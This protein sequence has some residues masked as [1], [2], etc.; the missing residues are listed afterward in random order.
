MT[1]SVAVQRRKAVEKRILTSVITA[2]LNAGYMISIDNGDNQGGEDYELQN[3]TSVNQVLKSCMLTDDE[4]LY[5]IKDGKV[6][7]WAYFVYGNDGWDVLNDYTV[8]LDPIIGDGTDTQK[9][10][11]SFDK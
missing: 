5:A 9:L 10:I 2:M 11:D 4:R 8:N 6:F 3:G 1:T 7:G